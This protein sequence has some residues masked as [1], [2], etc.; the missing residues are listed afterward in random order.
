MGLIFL[1]LHK[2]VK[3]IDGVHLNSNFIAAFLL[4]N[5]DADDFDT[6]GILILENN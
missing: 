3:L 4:K 5:S 1:Q 2:A 6:Q